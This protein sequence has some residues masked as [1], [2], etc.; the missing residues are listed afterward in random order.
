MTAEECC[1]TVTGSMR[2]AMINGDVDAWLRRVFILNWR[3]MPAVFGNGRLRKN[4]F[5]GAASVD[6]R[7]AALP[8]TT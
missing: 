1:K 3:L 7:P 4:G 6:R 5:S 2:D 8:A